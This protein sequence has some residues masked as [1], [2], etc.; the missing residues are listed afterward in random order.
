MH[1]AN[2]HFIVSGAASGLGATTAQMLIEA[3]AKVMLVDLNAEAVAAKAQALGEQ[4]RY[5]VADISNEQAAKA[6]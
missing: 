4:A 1:I 3:G 5:A 2:K 6:A